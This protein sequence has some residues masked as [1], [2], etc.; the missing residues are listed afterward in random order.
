M[1]KIYEAPKL[2][3]DEYVADTMIAS[4]TNGWA[5]AGGLGGSPK[6]GNADNNQNCWGARCVPGAPDPNNPYNACAD[7]PWNPAVGSDYSIC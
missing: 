6:N 7:S 3:V 2:F 4:S 5:E 1:K